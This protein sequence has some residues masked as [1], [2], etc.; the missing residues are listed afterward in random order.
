M[1][2]NK[3]KYMNFIT[4]Q[5]FEKADQYRRNNIPKKMYKFVSLN[6][7]QKCSNKCEYDDLNSKKINSILN[8]KFWVSTYD[9]LN[10]PFELKSIFIEQEKIEE[11]GCPMD[12][13]EM[14]L[15]I[16]RKCLIGCFTTSVAN[17]LPMWAHYANNHKGICIEYKVLSPDFFYPVIY[18]E[19]R[20]GCSNI[21]MNFINLAYKDMI[22]IILEDEKK[23]LELYGEI[24]RKNCII[25]HK[26]WEYEDEYRY[27]F[28][29]W[30]SVNG[31]IEG[32]TLFN[33]RDMG[34]EITG[35]Y[36]GMC[37]EEDY[38]NKLIVVAKT[39]GVK[40]Y[41]MYFNNKADDYALDYKEIITN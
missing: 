29:N 1:T 24:I 13:V 8:G 34:I 18:E 2:F 32:G 38:K 40:I 31:E 33:T 4:N 7:V 15:E 37:C 14:L 26:S 35:I 17:N 20:I 21:V 11:Q 30:D 12:L 22:G 41:Q 39:L 5:E 28:H 25:K 3:D 27:I 9:N 16:V 36:L 19:R 6:D 23:K 10:D